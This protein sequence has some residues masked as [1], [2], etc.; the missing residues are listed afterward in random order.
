M[1]SNLL[2]L[3]FLHNGHYI[4]LNNQAN[5][6][7][8]KAKNDN[9]PTLVAA[10]TLLFSIEFLE[11]SYNHKLLAANNVNTCWQL[12]GCL[13]SNKKILL[14]SLFFNPKKQTR[15]NSRAHLFN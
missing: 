6:F 14:I 11:I 12:L 5:P 2:I 9:E 4:Y 10:M 7:S 8:E 13:V 3:S 1:L 15:P